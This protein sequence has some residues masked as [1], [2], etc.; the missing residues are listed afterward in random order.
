[1]NDNIAVST[2]KSGTTLRT[3]PERAEENWPPAV[4]AGAFQTGLNLMRNLLRRGVKVCAFDANPKQTGFSSRYGKTYLCPNPDTDP[5]A[6]VSF[7]LNLARQI[8]RKPVLIPA[9]DQFVSAIGAHVDQL[10]DHFIFLPEGF[11]IQA[12][13]ATKERQYTLAEA[14]GLPTPR[15]Q[16]IRSL[17]ELEEFARSANFPCLIKPLHCREWERM[18]AGHP[19]L[20]QKLAVAQTPE[21]LLASY[22][23]VTEYTPE[24]VVQEIIQGPDTAKFCYMA[25]LS[26]SG[27]ILGGCL[28]RQLRTEPVN[29][30]S[31][32]VVEPAVEPDARSIC[33]HFLESI[34]YK[35]LCELEL[36][37]DSRDGK[38]RLI[39][40][41][42]RYSITTDS[43]PHAGV[44]TGW[45]HYLDL[46]GVDVQPVQQNS[47]DFRHVVL[48][49]DVSSIRSNMR[50]G[51]LNW[52][53][54]LHSY[55]RPLHFFDFDR[56]DRKLSWQ[57]IVEV[58]KTFLYPYFRRIFPKRGGQ[59]A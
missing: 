30:G 25:C 52:S 43:A 19:L 44:D 5:E 9:A 3:N 15:T 35:G 18:P 45:L 20:N 13:L 23:S 58:V 1:M 22:R 33:D 2:A 7:M 36:K 54:L 34:G 8:G 4:V 6:W 10:K 39:E 48:R 32:T 31:A 24:L 50:A 28:V 55:R 21:E 46:I 11:A 40:I 14:N 37:R 27:K 29:F 47:Y 17:S 12:Q 49:R 53:G 41:N 38:I 26:R 51:I 16:F 59:K 42:P 57:T 56:R